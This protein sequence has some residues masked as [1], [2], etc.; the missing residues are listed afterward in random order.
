MRCHLNS[1]LPL[2]TFSV[3]G[4]REERIKAVFIGESGVGKTAIIK[5]IEENRFVDNAM[6]TVG[7]AYVPLKVEL[8]NSGKQ[9]IIGLWDTA[10]QE[11][12][13][14]VVSTL[15]QNAQMVVLVFDIAN[16]ESYDQCSTWL[17]TARDKAPVDAQYFLVA[18]KCDLVGSEAVTVD[19]MDKYAEENRMVAVVLTS[20]KTGDGF[21]ELRDI[22]TQAAERAINPDIEVQKTVDIADTEPPKPRRKCC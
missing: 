14:S 15:F 12:Y 9:V 6:E 13:R 4:M 10:G 20:A 5:R 2:S 1:F 18:N 21:A 8:P 17:N 11:R 16:R 7:G 3:L 19:E 22:L